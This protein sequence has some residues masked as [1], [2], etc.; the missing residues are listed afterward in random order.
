MTLSLTVILIEATG[1]ITL[2]LP[3]MIVLMIAKW[4]GDIFT[5]VN[6]LADLHLCFVFKL[7]QTRQSLYLTST[8]SKDVDGASSLIKLL[9][10]CGLVFIFSIV[11]YVDSSYDWLAE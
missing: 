1:N 10:F 8:V 7:T 4:V 5:E 11:L 6:H 9:E 2:G 3:V